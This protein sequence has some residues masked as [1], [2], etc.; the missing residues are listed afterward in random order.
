MVDIVS[1]EVR[2][3][4][5]ASVRAKNTKPELAIRKEL[6]RRG[7]RYRLHVAGLP[8]KPD[9][10]LPRYKTVIFVHG[11]FWHGHSCSLFRL[12]ATRTAFWQ[13]KISRNRHND[14]LAT[15]ALAVAG[16][17]I[18]TVWECA[19]KGAG[20]LGLVRTVDR[21]EEWLLTSQKNLEVYGLAEYQ[22]G[23]AHEE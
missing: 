3:R 15:A 6:F 23:D 14:R 7:F 8:G 11:C 16:W 13:E 20:R 1:R 12:P 9:I 17:R 22:R 4:M 2:S 19:L 5:M 18:A 10:V 21:I